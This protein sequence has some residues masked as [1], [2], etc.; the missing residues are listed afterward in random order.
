MSPHLQAVINE[1]QQLSSTEQIQLIS[2]ISEFLQKK[3]KTSD[4]NNDFWK[5]KTFIQVFN[6]QPVQPVESLKD[7]RADFWPKED[8]VDEFNEYIYNQRSE[9]RLRD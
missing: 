1:A 5:S 9:V 6:E 8:S 4:L 3:Y 7:L 2:A